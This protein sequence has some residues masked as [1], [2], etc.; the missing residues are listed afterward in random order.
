MKHLSSL[1]V[2]KVS[3]RIWGGSLFAK[4]SS[5][6]PHGWKSNLLDE[7]R[8]DSSLASMDC[9]ALKTV[10]TIQSKQWAI[11][12]QVILKNV[13]I[14]RCDYRRMLALA[15]I[16]GRRIVVFIYL[17]ALLVGFNFSLIPLL[18][19]ILK[20]VVWQLYHHLRNYVYELSL[21]INELFHFYSIRIAKY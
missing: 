18:Y 20:R 9:S 4:S 14:K 1:L 19:E 3:H 17:P 11:V 12:T 6:H 21:G 13:V 8:N 15:I 2:L 16:A 10:L 7:E 5:F